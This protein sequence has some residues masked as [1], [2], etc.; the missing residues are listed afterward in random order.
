MHTRIIIVDCNG[1]ESDPVPA[2]MCAEGAEKYN[3]WMNAI[4]DSEE[5][6]D[7]Y[8]ANHEQPGLFDFLSNARRHVYLSGMAWFLHKNGVTG[9]GGVIVHECC[10]VCN[11]IYLA[12]IPR[13]HR[14]DEGARR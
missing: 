3:A 6:R 1:L 7:D 8:N 13:Q 10:P 14:T 4:D 2:P 5:A 12:R 9:H 11:S